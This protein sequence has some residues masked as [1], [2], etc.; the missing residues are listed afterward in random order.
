MSLVSIVCRT[1]RIHVAKQCHN[2]RS[3]CYSSRSTEVPLRCH[4]PSISSTDPSGIRRRLLVRG[5]LFRV[6]VSVGRHV[7]LANCCT[8][9]DRILQQSV[10][11]FHQQPVVSERKVAMPDKDFERL[12]GTVVPKQYEL[13]LTPDLALL[14]FQ[15][16]CSVQIEVSVV[17]N[18]AHA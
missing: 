1:L 11:F 4:L 5:P 7:V 6:G 14:T 3:S 10:R 17:R 9:A 16:K 8:C 2:Y 15:G 13:V 12:P 18:R